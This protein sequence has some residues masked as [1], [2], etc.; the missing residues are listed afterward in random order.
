MGMLAF[1][2]EEYKAAEEHFALAFASCL[3]KAT[4]NL[5][6]ASFSCS[7]P[8]L[9]MLNLV[10]LYCRQILFHLLPLRLLRG[11]LPSAHLLAEFPLLAQTYGPF[12]QALR[13]SD[14]RAYDNALRVLRAKLL[15]TGGGGGGVWT[16]M[17]R[18]RE[19]VVR[20]RLK[21]MWVPTYLSIPKHPFLHP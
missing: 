3:W 6:S 11:L 8:S 20:G 12:I 5:E 21:K 17:E 1:L 2:E 7:K 10:L 9:S 4:R 16:A 15:K 14:I 13:T 19:V 18:G